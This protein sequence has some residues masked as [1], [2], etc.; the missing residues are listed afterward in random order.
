MFSSIKWKFILVYFL[1]VFIAM[2]IV[3]VFI[4]QRTETKQLEHI[5]D[6]MNQHVETIISASS[7]ITEDDWTSVR[8]EIQKTIN[9]WRLDGRETLY[10]INN[11]DVPTI[12]AST[13]KNYETANVQNALSYKSL[14]P[15]LI[16]K[17]LDG[18]KN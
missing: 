16:L 18:E 11:A 17:A 12:I 13:S 10:V 15:T 4:I 6:T 2:V 3:A 9:E 5:T 7:Y 8:G 1:L 14:D